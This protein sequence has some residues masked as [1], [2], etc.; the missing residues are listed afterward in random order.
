MFFF[1]TLPGWALAAGLVLLALDRCVLAL[2]DLLGR[3][4]DVPLPGWLLLRLERRREKK[5]AGALRRDEQRKAV[6]QVRLERRTERA[7]QAARKA[8]QE[9]SGEKELLE[10][11]CPAYEKELAA[12]FRLTE[13]AA[14]AALYRAGLIQQKRALLLRKYPQRPQ[15]CIRPQQED[16][17]YVRR[18]AEFKIS[19]EDAR[20]AY[21]L[22]SGS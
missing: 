15:P 9:L 20:L 22:G 4:T 19:A 2:T 8:L 1:Y 16:A 12:R 18:G 10:F 14:S 11:D 21:A 13:K 6:E 7:A 17:E 3:K 5:R